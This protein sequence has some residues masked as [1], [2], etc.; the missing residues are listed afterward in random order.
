MTHDQYSNCK[1]HTAG[2]L[3]ARGVAG[4]AGDCYVPMEGEGLPLVGVLGVCTQGGQALCTQEQL[5]AHAAAAAAGNGGQC[6]GG[7]QQQQQQ[8][9]GGQQGHASGAVGGAGGSTPAGSLDDGSSGAE[10]DDEFNQWMQQ[11]GGWPGCWH[12]WS[13]QPLLMLH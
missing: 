7:R 11:V 12:C 5:Q 1:L 2:D 13:P 6:W 9:E 10:Q 4:V 8:Q 3:I